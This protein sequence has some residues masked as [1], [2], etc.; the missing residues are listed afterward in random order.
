MQI[1]HIKLAEALMFV[2]GDHA[3]DE[4]R[5]MADLHDR[6]GAPRS[7]IAWN[8]TIKAVATAHRECVKAAA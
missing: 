6:N 2:H 7:A 5:R 8:E 3:I 1:N 4:A